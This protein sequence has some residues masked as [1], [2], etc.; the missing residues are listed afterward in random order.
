MTRPLVDRLRA[1]PDD[2]NLWGEFYQALR[3]RTYAFVFTLC[4]GDAALADDVTQDVFINF[5]TRNAIQKVA[6]LDAA[7]AYLRAMARNHVVDEYR[8][9]S[10]HPTISTN[11]VSPAE[12]E[13]SL[14]RLLRTTV[15]DIDFT[16]F[17]DLSRDDR[18]LLE[19]VIQGYTISQIAE[20]KGVTY[21][22]AAVR[23]HR[24]RK[25]LRPEVKKQ[26]RRSF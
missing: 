3:P 24:L 21:S 9:W 10:A 23:L 19:L 25:R 18:K 1:S 11:A 6:T 13:R 12:L 20:Q 2:A 14:R 15:D 17:P 4:H 7:I 5:I 8:R 26:P 16:V 22:A